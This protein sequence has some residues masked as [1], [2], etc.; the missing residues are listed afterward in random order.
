MRQT[1]PEAQSN[2]YDFAE[3]VCTDEQR[4]QRYDEAKMHWMGDPDPHERETGRHP[5]VKRVRDGHEYTYSLPNM[6]AFSIARDSIAVV[7]KDPWHH[8]Q[9]PNAWFYAEHNLAS[10]KVSEPRVLRSHV[11]QSV[12]R[13]L[14]LQLV[15]EDDYGN[16][17]AGMHPA[18]HQLPYDQRRVE[19]YLAPDYKLSQG[20]DYRNGLNGSARF[21]DIVALDSMIRVI[22]QTSRLL[23]PRS[24]SHS[25]ED[26]SI[27]LAA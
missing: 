5:W 17:P 2:L 7:L 16:W 13:K 10:G 19:G 9:N 22:R 3:W 15:D 6:A 20:A 8:D 4:L 12:A 23:T 25:S 21:E 27:R 11:E 14:W 24:I 26:S 18:L 1:S